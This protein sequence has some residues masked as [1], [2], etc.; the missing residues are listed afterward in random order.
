MEIRESNVT[1]YKGYFKVWLK[2]E[3]SEEPFEV[4]VEDKKQDYYDNLISD[5]ATEYLE[6]LCFPERSIK[7]TDGSILSTENIVRIK[8]IKKWKKV[9]K[10]N[11]ILEDIKKTKV[12]TIGAW[13]WKKIE[14]ELYND[15]IKVTIEITNEG[16]WEEVDV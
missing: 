7:A 13:W 3:F 4:F 12:K 15:G 1:L 14:Q 10:F 5:Q 11:T 16:D 2:R 8:P 6:S 9:I